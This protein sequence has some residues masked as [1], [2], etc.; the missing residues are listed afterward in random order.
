MN[1]LIINT[2]DQQIDLVL[3]YSKRLYY[4]NRHLFGSNEKNQIYLSNKE[5]KSL[6]EITIFVNNKQFN[7]SNIN[8]F[9]ENNTITINNING[10]YSISCS[11]SNID[12]EDD[13]LKSSDS[14]THY[15][16]KDVCCNE[17][18]TKGYVDPAIVNVKTPK[19]EKYNF[20]QKIVNDLNEAIKANNIN[21]VINKY[22]MIKQIDKYF[23]VPLC[24]FIYQCEIFKPYKSQNDI[25]IPKKD[26]EFIKNMDMTFESYLELDFS[27]QYEILCIKQIATPS[28]WKFLTTFH[29][30]NNNYF[31][32]KNV[33][34]IVDSFSLLMK[35]ILSNNLCLAEMLINTGLANED[36]CSDTNGNT[37][38]ILA[39]NRNAKN[40]CLK[41]LENDKCK[42]MHIT[43]YNANALSY[44]VT[45][46]NTEIASIIL[47]YYPKPLKYSTCHALSFYHCCSSKYLN[48]CQILADMTDIDINN[49]FIKLILCLC[50]RYEWYDIINKICV[51]GSKTK[52]KLLCLKSISVK[53][54]N[55]ELVYMI[56]ISNQNVKML[57]DWISECINL[58]ELKCVNNELT[59]LP[60][61]PKSLKV[62]NCG[63]NN[64]TVLPEL[65][66]SLKYLDCDY[67]KLTY[68]PEL[69][70]NLVTLQI[71]NNKLLSKLPKI[72]RRL[73]SLYCNGCQLTELPEFPTSL[74]ELICYNN[75]ITQLP[76]SL[77]LCDLKFIEISNNQIEITPKIKEFVANIKHI[78]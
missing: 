29:N 16:I 71:S 8:E 13:K 76:E 74:E 38:L 52:D 54:A 47:S 21:M 39:C 35:L 45:K 59:V 11:N 31:D 61:L 72:P 3:N 22:K 68:L 32:F 63:F 56:N 34:D 27:L 18:N 10:V 36:Y 19:I 60:Q 33:N 51:N 28:Y 62:L 46:N 57:P 75:K 55:P 58:R 26:I 41:L 40:I 44:A 6:H 2:T 12:S 73:K 69:P 23:N 24:H 78:Y 64:L 5:K 1:K 50:Y 53:P 15:I 30:I 67:N 48:L 25:F 37:A 49:R 20:H 70:D 9:I 42:P 17:S 66:Q 65:P 4:C 43:K 77:F 7:C 14:E